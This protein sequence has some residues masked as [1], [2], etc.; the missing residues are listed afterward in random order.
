MAQKEM[1]AEQSAAITKEMKAFQAQNLSQR[2]E[3]AK[4]I[5][6]LK[7]EML[8]ESY[9]NQLKMFSDIETLA[10]QIVPGK[11]QENKAIREKMKKIRKEFKENSKNKRKAFREDK[12]KPLKLQAKEDRKKRRQEFKAKMKQYRK[13][14]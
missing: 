10:N 13:K 7:A 9:E 3:N 11:R 5:Y 8:K 4:K 6:D 2:K 12:I 14:K 1:S